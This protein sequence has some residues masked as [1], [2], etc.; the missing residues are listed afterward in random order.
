MI[1]NQSDPTALKILMSRRSVKAREMVAP[2]PN[3]K[4]L[5]QIL[6]AGRRVPDHG[7]LTPWR[8]FVFEG[9]ARARFGAVIQECYFDEEAEPSKATAKGLANYP[10]QAP[11]LVV[12]GCHFSDEKHIP[13]W[14]QT[15]SC[16]AAC[17]NMLTAAH[18]L[19]FVGQWLTGWA[20]YS[21][22]VK[23]YL[24]LDGADGIVGFLFFGS[25]QREPTERPRPEAHEVVKHF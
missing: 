20:A 12:V 17:Q 5:A 15:L 2:G 6:A 18:M 19:G 3:E 1:L 21:E 23:R 7:K 22:G 10:M 9:E 25:Q 13:A 16:G 8:F 4:E 11:V 24:G 14:E